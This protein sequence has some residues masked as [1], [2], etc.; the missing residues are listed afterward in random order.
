MKKF[1]L[2]L[3]LSAIM[4]GCSKPSPTPNQ[5][6]IY[7][8]NNHYLKVLVI[9]S[10]EYL[11]SGGINALIEHKGNCKNPIHIRWK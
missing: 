5:N 11:Y 3:A 8:D 10:C 1:S 6:N 7:E 2:I 4:F 9:D